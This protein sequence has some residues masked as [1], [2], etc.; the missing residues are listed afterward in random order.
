MIETPKIENMVKDFFEAF[1][2]LTGQ[3]KIYFLAQIDKV[4]AGKNDKDKKI[5]LSLIKA[6]REGKSQ[7][8]A[9]LAMKKV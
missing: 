8:E 4:L 7:E 5:F 3:E 6:A 9:V 2:K 1:N